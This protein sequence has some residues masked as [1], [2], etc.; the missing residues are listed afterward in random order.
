MLKI[1]NK[2]IHEFRANIAKALAHRTRMEIVDLLAE[3]KERCVGE[4]TEILDVS[5]S[6]VSKHLS[7]LKQAG[8]I[9]SRKEGLKNYYYLEAPCIV[10]F[11]A[12]LDDI[13]IKE[14]DQRKK[15]IKNIKGL[16]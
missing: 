14:L 5:Q 6:A 11:F 8:I 12:C 4:L 15:E 10:D 9:A 7:T 2:S 3:K 16:K 13:L 1:S